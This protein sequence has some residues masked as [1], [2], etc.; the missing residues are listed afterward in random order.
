MLSQNQLPT[1]S[2]HHIIASSL[3]VKLH[4]EEGLS[5]HVSFFPLQSHISRPGLREGTV[6]SSMARADSVCGKSARRD[7]RV[8]ITLIAGLTL[9]H[10]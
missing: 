8:S 2:G 4:T 5:Q 1:L 9:I 6:A 3:Y 10:L 7:H